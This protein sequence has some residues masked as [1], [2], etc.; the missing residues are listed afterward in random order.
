MFLLLGKQRHS[1]LT[2]YILNKVH[3]NGKS[4]LLTIFKFLNFHSFSFIWVLVGVGGIS[5]SVSLHL[6]LSLSLSSSPP[7]SLYLFCVCIRAGLACLTTWKSY[8]KLSDRPID[9]GFL[10]SVWHLMEGSSCQFCVF[11][12]GGSINFC[13][14]YFTDTEHFSFFLQKCKSLRYG[15]SEKTVASQHGEENP[16]ICLLLVCASHASHQASHALHQTNHAPHQASH[17]LHQV[18]HAHHQA[19]HIFSLA[20]LTLKPQILYPKVPQRKLRLGAGEMAQS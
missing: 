11:F 7:L 18:S 15:A 8:W 2:S 16:K 17:T 10:W 6:P 9:T 3:G 14:W 1:F 5:L 4:G 20:A 19:S 13:P 12:L